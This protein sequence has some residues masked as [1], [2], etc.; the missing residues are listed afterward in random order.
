M[1]DPT[2]APLKPSRW[3]AFSPSVVRENSSR[4]TGAL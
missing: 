1:L 2:V 3:V 4:T